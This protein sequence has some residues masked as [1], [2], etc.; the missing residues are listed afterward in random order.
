MTGILDGFD[1]SIAMGPGQ[2]WTFNGPGGVGGPTWRI[3]R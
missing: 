2:P 1:I 3:V